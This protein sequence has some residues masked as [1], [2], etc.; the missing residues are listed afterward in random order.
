MSRLVGG[1]N[2]S[3]GVESALTR[4][5]LAMLGSW[6]MKAGVSACPIGCKGV[7]GDETKFA[8]AGERRQTA[9][10][11]QSRR[12]EGAPPEVTRLAFSSLRCSTGEGSILTFGL[13][14]N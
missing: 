6:S 11:L 7:R 14:I 1:D 12:P 10:A 2:T 5:E 8:A 9:P 13:K 3:T 4:G